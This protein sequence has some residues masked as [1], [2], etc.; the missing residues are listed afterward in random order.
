MDFLVDINNI[1]IIIKVFVFLVNIERIGK[2]GELYWFMIDLLEL[3]L[4]EIDKLWLS[5]KDYNYVNVDFIVIYVFEVKY[6]LLDYVENY[7]FG[8]VEGKM[9]LDLYKVDRKG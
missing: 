8:I 3:N 7:M 4:M 9:W 5:E 1:L 2:K 6:E